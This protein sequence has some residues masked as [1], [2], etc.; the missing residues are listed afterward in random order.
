GWEYGEKL[1]GT[2][3]LFPVNFAV[4]LYDNEEKQ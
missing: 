3:G 2:I 4:R 1:D